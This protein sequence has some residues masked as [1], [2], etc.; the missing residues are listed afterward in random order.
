M[1]SLTSVAPP[2]RV[3]FIVSPTRIELADGTTVL[4]RPMRPEDV[5]LVL[6]MHDRLS[7]DTI[8]FRYLHP[9]KPTF[10]ELDS[11]ARCRNEEGA[12]FVL[13]V[14]PLGKV[15][16]LVFFKIDPTDPTTAQPAFLIED[17]FQNKGL[18]RALTRLLVQ[19]AVMKGIRVFEATVHPA[20]RKMMHLFETSGLP[21]EAKLAYGSYEVRVRL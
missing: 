6:E 16:G 2:T 3:Q 19:D 14:E 1:S 12:V 7:A 17:G 11:L 9:Y 8:Y 10:A 5:P 20:N 13:V 15:I 18:G 4:V 21:Y